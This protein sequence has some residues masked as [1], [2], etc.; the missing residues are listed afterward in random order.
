MEVKKDMG[1]VDI[2]NSID[3]QAVVLLAIAYF[4]FKTKK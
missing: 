1:I 2:V 3:I 4:Y